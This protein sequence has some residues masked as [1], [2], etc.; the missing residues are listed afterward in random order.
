VTIYR[1]I[2]EAKKAKGVAVSLQCELLGVSES[3]YWAWARRPPS[4]RDLHDAWLT[5]RI[6]QVHAASGGR[7]GSR[8]CARCWP[9]R[10][11]CG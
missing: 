7:Y 10:G 4:D 9:V 6:R 11:S 8:A 5:E 2:T 1:H 3:G